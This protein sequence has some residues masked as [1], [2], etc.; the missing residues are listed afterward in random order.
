MPTIKE[1][2]ARLR[3]LGLENEFGYRAETRRIP[4]CLE[5]DETLRGITA[6]IYQGRRWYVLLTEQR[7]LLLAKPTMGSPRL[8]AIEFG[9]VRNIAIKKG[10]IFGTLTIETTT[11]SYTF[12][13]VLKKS[14]PSFLTA[15]GSAGLPS[16]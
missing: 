13:N 12:T 4:E 14:I 8:V 2:K 10:L 6:G 3:E 16:T 15:T 7:L 1:I 5:Q 9:Q 11:D